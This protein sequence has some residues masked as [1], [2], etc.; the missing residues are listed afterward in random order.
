[1]L[2]T[3][4][5][6]SKSSLPVLQ[7]LEVVLDLGRPPTARF[8]T[9]DLQLAEEPVS[10]ADLQSAIEQVEQHSSCLALANTEPRVHGHH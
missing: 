8:P 6:L 9:G 4:P 7:L 5:P 10:P 1:M 3:E 2:V